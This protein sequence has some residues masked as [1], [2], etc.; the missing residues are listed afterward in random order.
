MRGP[1]VQ[2]RKREGGGGVVW[3]RLR[4]KF[5]LGKWINVF[6]QKKLKSGH[7]YM[8]YAEYTETNERSIFQFLVLR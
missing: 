3:Q 1:N 8:N 7:I 5:I 6:R 4:T 2:P